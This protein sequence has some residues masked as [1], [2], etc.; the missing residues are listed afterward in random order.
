MACQDTNT[1]IA[2]GG[3]V[4]ENLDGTVSV[5]TQNTLNVLAPLVLTQPCC[6]ALNSSYT[7]DINKQKCLWK[8]QNTCTLDSVFNINL[9]P[10]GNGA[11]LFYVDDD[12]SCN[13]K[14]EFDYL[15][16]IK[17]ETLS[18]LLTDSFDG[19]ED[20]DPNLYGQIISLQYQ[21]EQQTILCDQINSQI[22]QLNLE[23]GGTPYSII[24]NQ[25]N[26]QLGFI[27]NDNIVKSFS[28]TGFSDL[29]DFTVGSQ[30]RT[31]QDTDYNLHLCLTEP[32]G[33][34]AWS[35]ILGEV[36]YISFINGNQDSYTCENVI[37]IF[38][39]NES[40][41]ASDPQG[42]QLVYGCD[43]PI[44]AR[45]NL[46]NQLEVLLKEQLSCQTLLT[47][48]TSQ[49]EILIN[50]GNIL[51][52]NSCLNPVDFFES[53]DMSVSLNVVSNG[54]PQSVYT[55][56][57]FFNSIGFGQL[58]QYLTNTDNS[59]FYVCGGADCQ[60]FLLNGEN[61]FLCENIRENI[62]NTLFIQSNLE[63]TQDGIDTFNQS[64]PNNVFASNWVTYS[65]IITDASVLSAITNQNIS[66]SVVIN[67][68]CADICVLIDNIK[69]NKECESVSERKLF[70]TKSP[71]F[72]LE[73]IIDNKKSWVQKNNLDN[74]VFDIK[75]P[76][77]TDLI[78][79]T[80]YNTNDERLI[81][82]TKEIDLD[83]SL[84]SAI[85][86]D[87]WCYLLDNN[88]LFTGVTNCEICNEDY[89]QFQDDLYFE[90]MDT[91]PYEFMDGNYGDTNK[92]CGD[93]LI[94]FD[95]L[96]TKPLSA[97]TVLED[98]KYY[99]TSELIDAKNRQTISSYATLRALYDR[100]LNSHQYCNT[101]SAAFTYY[102][103][104]EFANLLG[105]YWVD[106]IEQ[107]VPSTAIWGSVRVYSN[108]IFDQQKYKYKAYS[109][110]LCRNPFIGDSV[111]SPING[112]SGFSST[113][114][115]N[116]VDISQPTISGSTGL[117]I[118]TPSNCN[119]IHVAQMNSGSEF[120]G[121]VRVVASTACQDDIVINECLMQVSVDLNG[122]TATANVESAALPLTYEWS[123]GETTESSTFDT[124]GEY[125]VI[126]T[127]A[128]CCSVTINFEIPVVK[129][130]CWYTF[131]DSQALVNSEF[132]NFAIPFYNYEMVSFLINGEEV[133]TGP[134]LIYTLTASNFETILT[135]AGPSYTNFV[136][137]LNESF[138]TLGLNNYTAIQALDG[139]QHGT[140][141]Q[142]FYILR[143]I[144]DTFSIEINKTDSPTVNITNDD[145][146]G[147][148]FS[149]DCSEDN[150]ISEIT[151]K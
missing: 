9:N 81:I 62:V 3:Q 86:T 102:T 31:T 87:V 149:V 60:P 7:F 112:T 20:I 16:K 42:P 2:N 56:N 88:C 110:L 22:E 92:C 30:K 41:L 144:D 51:M 15:I 23:I 63:N 49:L 28:K 10:Q 57:N 94:Q 5:Y 141:N 91:V 53:L 137:F 50:R 131:P 90:F 35:Q 38:T 150:F 36:N 8:S 48:L 37:E 126:V 72:K 113:V 70:V 26:S 95:E 135:T 93:N 66:F 117:T 25:S 24:C 127:D 120:I 33:L 122:Y 1:I 133:I 125:S 83:V 124:F 52:S 73:K 68:T 18:N 32:E 104:E 136:E 75:N 61:Q 108:T 6:L 58:Y 59:G 140:D 123:N 119:V 143:P 98:F 130:A 65:N 45:I 14:V 100:Y 17:C 29:T 103:M 142:G 19:L 34:N 47:S 46:V 67:H 77:E 78:R 99:L 82:N 74:R 64:L 89:K 84:A 39:T 101:Y 80:S 138:Q 132:N 114:E 44:N 109:T 148:D 146:I 4:I 69:L 96:M 55:D 118:S 40:N 97:I 106:I 76:S 111:L 54:Q 116:F 115:V 79:Q 85:E 128:N 121:T 21:I 107:V 134:P 27:T 139:N 12:E 71:G 43:T 105:N 151:K 129:T 11:S 147:G 145:M 13:I